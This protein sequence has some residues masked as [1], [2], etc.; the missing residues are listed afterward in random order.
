MFFKSSCFL[1]LLLGLT[2]MV[3]S[4]AFVLPKDFDKFVIS[5]LKMFEAKLDKDKRLAKEDIDVILLLF[6]IINKRREDLEREQREAEY[7][8]LRQGR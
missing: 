3:E 7:W 8:H 2:L 1:V 6:T 4:L 5:T